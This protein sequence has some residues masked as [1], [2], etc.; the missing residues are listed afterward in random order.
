MDFTSILA[1][2]SAGD[3][4]KGHPA[5][6]LKKVDNNGALKVYTDISGHV[7]RTDI[8]VPGGRVI[9]IKDY[10]TVPAYSHY[11]V[12]TILSPQDITLGTLS[13]SPED[14]K[15]PTSM[16]RFF[17]GN[18]MI[19]TGTGDIGMAIAHELLG[20]SAD[21][22]QGAHS[23]VDPNVITAIKAFLQGKK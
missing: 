2:P 18:E 5:T 11:K 17:D 19:G 15:R 14:R 13:I 9:V 10:E 23:S 6:I 4:F 16:S 12:V 8:A 21:S 1:K 3:D 7:Q 20:V 22:L